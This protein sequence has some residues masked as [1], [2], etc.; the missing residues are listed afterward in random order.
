M[1]KV[2]VGIN[3]FGRIGRITFRAIVENF[4]DTLEVVAIND[5]A[6]VATNAH[7]L[8]HDTNYGGFKGTVEVAE[9]AIVVNGKAVTICKEKDPA[10]LPW[11]ALGVDIVIESTGFFTDADKAAAH[12]AAGAKKVIISAPAKGDGVQ[13]IVLGVNDADLDVKAYNVFSNASCTT[14]CLAPLAKALDE[15]W[16][17]EHGFMN[18]I[19]SYTNDQRMNDQVHSD[20]RRARAGAA[21][22]IPTTTGAAKAI[23][24]VMP[25]LKGKLDGC[26]LRVPTPTVSVVDL[27]AELK[28][29]LPVGADGKIDLK[30]VKAALKA[31]CDGKY[32]GYSDE[33]PV[34]SDF[35]GD[36]R[37]SVLDV[38]FTYAIAPRGIKVLS[39]YDNEWGYSNRL[40]ELC[41]KIAEQL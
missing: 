33:E 31:K 36:P 12:I 11:A 15:L 41:E 6:P 20:M 3:G 19:H 8:K 14:N 17:I 25:H 18:T 13:T 7:L 1:G 32:L 26:S 35:R 28:R 23:G 27:T 37:S 9:D 40:A 24:L 29:D 21:N 34:S 22:I 30:A 2:Q 16:G 5:L 39:W 4:A 38:E 10:N